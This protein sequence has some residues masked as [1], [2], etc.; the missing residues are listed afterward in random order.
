[1][2]VTLIASIFGAY[3]IARLD[4]FGRRKVSVLFLSVYLFPPV[5]LAI[6]LF[7]AFSRLGLRGQLPVLIIVYVAQTVPVCVYMLRNYFETVPRSLEEAAEVDGC[8]RLGV[9]RR[10]TLPL[11]VP[12]IAATG[13]LVFMV[14]WNE[15][16][17]ALLFLVENRDNW[18]V[19]LG[20]SQLKGIETPATTLMAGSVILTVPVIVLFLFAERMMTE[21]LTARRRE[22]MSAAAPAGAEA[23]LAAARR[24]SPATGRAPRPCPRARQYPHQWSWDAAYIAVGWSWLDP[25]ARRAGARVAAARPVGATGACRTSCSTPAVPEDAYFPGPAFWRS[26]G[27]PGGPD[28]VATSGLTQ[29]PLHARAALEVGRRTPDGEAARAFLRARLPAPGRAARLPRRPARRAAAPASR[30]SSHPWESGLDDSPAWDAPLAAVALPRGGRRALRAPR[31]R[32]RRR[33]ASGRATPPTTASCTWPASTATGGY[34]DDALAERCPFARRGPAVQRH[35]AVVDARHGGDRRPARRG[36]RA[37]TARRRR[38]MHAA[39][40]SRL[41]DPAS[42]AS[43]P[44]DL[45]SGRRLGAAH[46]P[47]ARAAARPRPARATWPR[48]WRPSSARRTSAAP[49]GAR[50]RVVRPARRRSS[51]AAATGAG[52]SGSTS[53]GCWRAACARTG[54][55]RRPTRWRRR[56]SG[57]SA[58]G[59]MHEYFDP[60]SGDGRGSGEFSWTAA[61]LR[62]QL[63]AGEPDARRARAPALKVRPPGPILTRECSKDST[64]PPRAW[65]PSRHAS[66]PSPTT[67]P[68]RTRR[69]TSTCASASATSSTP[70]PAAPPPRAPQTGAGAAVGGRRARASPRARCS[71]PSSRSTSPSRARASCAC[72]SPTAR[73]R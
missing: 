4:F 68:T 7:V 70:R 23:L 41:W 5:L 11:A 10:I 53:T 28:G 50:R 26:D 16:L 67:W 3:A 33:R 34:A 39:L 8:T 66:T 15:F 45:R 13:L 62:R 18:T 37:A 19:S 12:A 20:V 59:G 42:G 69:A 51:T 54:S 32:A 73:R 24:C 72:G 14:A 22:G 29:P 38:G 56:R 21:G 43:S 64:P 47:V 27:A 55:T 71:A 48:R 9:I 44:R 63:R 35:L 46:R 1:M 57:W 52:R 2:V 65:P 60:L 40:L 25:A 6:P 49:D 17:F 61:L 31:P 58:G 36:P 30:R